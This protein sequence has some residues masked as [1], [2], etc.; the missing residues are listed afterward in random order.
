MDNATT[1][2]RINIIEVHLA[3]IRACFSLIYFSGICC[4][5]YCTVELCA[6]FEII[7][8]N[9]VPVHVSMVLRKTK[10]EVRKRSWL[11]KNYN[12]CQ[13]IR[14]QEIQYSKRNKKIQ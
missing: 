14:K 6:S 11:L 2:S 1:N 5:S 10:L 12:Y 9:Y 13:K 4:M 8:G 3:I 7:S